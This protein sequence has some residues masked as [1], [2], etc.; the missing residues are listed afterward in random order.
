MKR[1]EPHELATAL[2]KYFASHHEIT[3]VSIPYLTQQLGIH[4]PKHVWEQAFAL[5]N[6]S[7]DLSQAKNRPALGGCGWERS[8]RYAVRKRRRIR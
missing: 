8:S 3:S 6:K 7:G 5:L 1:V 2:R 4:A